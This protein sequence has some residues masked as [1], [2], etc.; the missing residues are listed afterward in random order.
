MRPKNININYEVNFLTFQRNRWFFAHDMDNYSCFH[1]YIFFYPIFLSSQF[2]PSRFSLNLFEIII[3]G[4]F[5]LREF[6]VPFQ[7]FLPIARNIFHV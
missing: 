2:V 7:Q 6:G 5:P 1:G 4:W 3:F